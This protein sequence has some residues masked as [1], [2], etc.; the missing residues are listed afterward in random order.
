MMF[1]KIKQKILLKNLKEENIKKN[2][3]SVLKKS[4]SY[5]EIKVDEK[6]WKM[7]LRKVY[8]NISTAYYY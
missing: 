4:L 3:K 1:I 2:D 8:I 6:I 7:P 5:L